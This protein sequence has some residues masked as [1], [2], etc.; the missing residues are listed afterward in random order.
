MSRND[1]LFYTQLTMSIIGMIFTG[2]MLI[3]DKK[4]ETYLPIFT[5]LLFCWMPSPYGTKSS[6]VS[7]HKIDTITDEEIKNHPKIDD[8]IG[9]VV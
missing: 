4:T 5:S 3:M 6:A 2:T 7:V 1:K 9:N 8:K